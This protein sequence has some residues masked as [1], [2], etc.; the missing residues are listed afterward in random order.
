MFEEAQERYKENEQETILT[1][2]DEIEFQ[3]STLCHLCETEIEDPEEKVRNHDHLTGKFL[4]ASHN[5]CNLSYKQPGN[6][7]VFLLS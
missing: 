4:G 2:E 7:F 5:K 6:F 1:R 3:N